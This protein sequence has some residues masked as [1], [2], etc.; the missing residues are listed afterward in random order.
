MV[1]HHVEMKSH[2]QKVEL[3]THGKT[4]SGQPHLPTITQAHDMNFRVKHY[5]SG[6][7]RTFFFSCGGPTSCM[8][9][10]TRA[11]NLHTKNIHTKLQLGN[12]KNYVV[13]ITFLLLLICKLE[14]APFE[15]FPTNKFAWSQSKP[16]YH[17]SIC[18]MW[19][20]LMKHLRSAVQPHD[21]DS[22][23][24]EFNSVS[25]FPISFWRLKSYAHYNK[26][27][28]TGQNL[29]PHKYALDPLHIFLNV[30]RWKA[31]F[32]SRRNILETP[33]DYL[34]QIYISPI[35]IEWWRRKKE[36][37]M[38]MDYISC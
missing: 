13:K 17:S 25:S 33:K 14:N 1:V 38:F 24:Q 5:L 9:N 15:S 30:R 26:P 28:W 6:N 7:K 29:L 3:F 8:E 36:F 35:S 27:H 34:A 10:Q 20:I 22:K 23:I 2:I 18:N 21:L 16:L 19:L 12:H 31:Y 37:W 32:Y 4:Q 11:E